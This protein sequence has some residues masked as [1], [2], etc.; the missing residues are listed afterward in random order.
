[1][2]RVRCGDVLTP[3]IV[4]CR[5]NPQIHAFRLI[6]NASLV[7]PAGLRLERCSVKHRAGNGQE[8]FGVADVRYQSVVKLIAKTSAFGEGLIV[9]MADR[10]AKDADGL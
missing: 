9:L 6:F 8:G 5:C 10:I 1:M 4:D 2:Q 7:L 3:Q